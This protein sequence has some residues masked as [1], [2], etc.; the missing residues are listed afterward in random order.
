MK[1]L[2]LSYIKIL[3]VNILIILTCIFN[4]T[5]AQQQQYANAY[6]YW[7]FGEDANDVQNVE[8]KIRI[9]MPAISTQWVMT[10]AW[11]ADPAH[12]GYLGFNTDE[13]GKG[14]AL[15]FCGMQARQPGE[16]V[17]S[18]EARVW[19]GVAERRLK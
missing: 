4:P 13:N 9:A 16:V 10:W 7:D 1:K 15:F 11:V 12:V 2:L 3:V 17:K 14:Q 6:T 19:D 8:Q 5:N 18:L